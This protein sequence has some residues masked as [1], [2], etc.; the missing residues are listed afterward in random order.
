MAKKK[1]KPKPPHEPAPAEKTRRQRMIELLESYKLDFE[2]LRRELGVP[3]KL[4]EEELAHLEKSLKHREAKLAIDP[5]ICLACG[6]QFSLRRD[7]RFHAPKRCPECKE[8]RVSPP[9]FS[10]IG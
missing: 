2:A 6:Y 3:R 10:I 9:A 8:E 4:L 1:P 5:A 7:R